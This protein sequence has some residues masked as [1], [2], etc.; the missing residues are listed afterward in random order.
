[1]GFL[2]F[3]KKNKSSGDEF[4]FPTKDEL[5]IP[6]AP[7]FKHEESSEAPVFPSTDDLEL[8][9]HEEEHEEPFDFELEDNPEIPIE[10]ND[11]DSPLFVRSTYFKAAVDELAVA[12]NTLSEAEHILTRV[13]DFDSD[14]DKE[15][16]KWRSQVADV[17]KKL[18]YAEKIL[19]N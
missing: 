2:S 4:K 19:F 11:G 18:L 10:R 17:Q 7:D 16:E 5:D 1:M 12:K 14:Q 9:Q 15:F 13:Q 6:P 3:L 8:P